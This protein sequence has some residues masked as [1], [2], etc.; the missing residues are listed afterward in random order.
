MELRFTQHAKNRMRKLEISMRDVVDLVTEQEPFDY[1]REGRPR[2]IGMVRGIR[3]RIVL[4]V[5]RPKLVVSLHERR[6]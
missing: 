1:D 5:D 2:Y 6:K 3:V 4:A